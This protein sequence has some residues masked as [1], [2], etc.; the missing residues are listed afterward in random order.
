MG[1]F[2][3]ALPPKAEL[4]LSRAPFTILPILRLTHQIKLDGEEQT[5]TPLE[6]CAY[7]FSSMLLLASDSSTRPETHRVKAGGDLCGSDRADPV[8]GHY[9]DE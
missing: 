8:A 3:G 1:V 6:I 5:P 2:G 4:T 9:G 7:L